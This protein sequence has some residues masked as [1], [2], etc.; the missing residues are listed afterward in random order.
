MGLAVL[1]G[2]RLAEQ[3]SRVRSCRNLHI[4]ARLRSVESSQA[5]IRYAGTTQR[6]N[7]EIQMSG[8]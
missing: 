1:V 3:V 5:I 7:K 4:C 8:D 2:F 6:R